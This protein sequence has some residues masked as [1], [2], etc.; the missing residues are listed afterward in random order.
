MNSEFE[1]AVVAGRASVRGRCARAPDSGGE[2]QRAED[3]V[4]AGGNRSTLLQ[5]ASSPQHAG[6]S[7]LSEQH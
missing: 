1:S 2:D 4:P 5:P 7:P 6:E 3:D